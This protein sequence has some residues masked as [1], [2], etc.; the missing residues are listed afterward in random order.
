[1]VKF[2]KVNPLSF[3]QE[4]TSMKMGLDLYWKKS[5]LSF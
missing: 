1:M 2:P 4:G 5:R 3:I